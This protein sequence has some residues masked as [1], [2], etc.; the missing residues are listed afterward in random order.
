MTRGAGN[1]TNDEAALAQAKA[2]SAAIAERLITM[3][4]FM[5]SEY[6]AKQKN[7]EHPDML[8]CMDTVICTLL[9]GLLSLSEAQFESH[10]NMF[11][12]PLTELIQY[13]S[14]TIRGLVKKLFETR[15]KNLM[16][17]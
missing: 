15:V 4:Q 12:F 7:K 1:D 5:L 13:G 14:P 6:V 11:Y 3:S 10:I 8:R 17:C 9:E 2:D 16:R